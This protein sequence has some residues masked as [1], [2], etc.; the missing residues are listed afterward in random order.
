MCWEAEP[1]VRVGLL[2]EKQDTI[3]HETDSHEPQPICFRI[4][5]KSVLI[6]IIWL[7]AILSA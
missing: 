2:K 7:I 4:D 5:Y 1:W 3:E 6:V